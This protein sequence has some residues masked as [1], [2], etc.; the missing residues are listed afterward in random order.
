M[1]EF[2]TFRDNPSLFPPHDVEPSEKVKA[3]WCI[4][5]CQA[6]YS[7]YLL[8]QCSWNYSDLNKIRELRAYGNGAQSTARYMD[9][10]LGKP[11]T[12][13]TGT[14]VASDKGPG[15]TANYA[16]KGYANINFNI[17]KI[18]PK[19]KTIVIGTFMNTEYDVFAD[20]ADDRSSSMRLNEKGKLWVEMKFKEEFARF[21]EE[22]G[23][24]M[25]TPD[26][27][28]ETEQELEMYATMGGFKLKSEI[29]IETA[30]QYTLFL[31]RWKE[32]KWKL[33]TD[34]FEIGKAGVKDYVNPQT[35]K[36]E[37]RYCDPE[38]CI[39]PYKKNTD[40]K[41]MP[42]AGEFCFYTIA[43]LRQLGEFTD[44]ELYTIAN[45]YK[46]F[47]GNNPNLI[48]DQ[49]QYDPMYNYAWN[50]FRIVVLDAEF[51]SDD[52]KYVTTF[53]NPD[54][55]IVERETK[56]GK[57]RKVDDKTTRKVK[58]MMV[59][60]CKW[61]V[62]TE[63]CWDYGHQFDIPRPTPSKA[64]L[65]F[66]F[67]KIEGPPM[68]EMMIQPLDQVQL[69]WIKMQNV[70]A[71]APPP[72]LAVD[73][74]TLNNVTVGDIKTPLELFKLRNQTGNLLY[75]ATTH[76]GYAP[77]ATGYRPIQE[78]QGGA[79]QALNDC[80]LQIERG[81]VMIQ[82]ITGINRVAAAGN[83]NPNDLV[84]TSELSLQASITAL[85]PLFGQYES[86]KERFCQNATLRIQLL[87]KIN[88]TYEVGYFQ[89]LGISNT[90][91]LKIGS[92]INN[93]MFNIRIQARPSAEERREILEAAQVSLQTG[94][95]GQIGITTSDYLVLV[96]FVNQGM[97]KMAQVYLAFRERKAQE[98]AQKIAMQNNQQQIEGN[99]MLEQQKAQAAK[100]LL[101]LQ[102]EMKKLETDLTTQSTIQIDN[103]KH[104]HRMKELTLELSVKSGMNTENNQ[105]KVATTQMANE[106][107]IAAK[108]ADMSMHDDKLEVEE[109]KLNAAKEKSET[110]EES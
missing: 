54:G 58:T 34:L 86:I 60:K 100:E 72:G 2:S 99:K 89:A 49:Y 12:N 37:A 106:T 95:N 59:Y 91:M 62:G 28:P 50:Q 108:G 36:V 97:L 88:G 32:I 69:G 76:K 27:V 77:Q 79:G 47:L 16:R 56:F 101:Q 22:T 110:K 5:F 30:L 3:D 51:K 24:K 15:A 85:Q 45:A 104:E 1:I 82:D 48:R 90:Q 67:S 92:E 96:N 11:T 17:L 64:E 66:H 78:L 94:R 87:V 57:E 25:D 109:M 31:S 43:D 83:P 46:N 102:Q 105:T 35:Q 61:I 42:F 40:Y 44:E 103:N 65:S 19:F 41:D 70:M 38:Y 68:I 13:V 74:G 107:S 21:Q 84:G 81:L 71:M 33:I 55:S 75:S 80:I 63:L 14:G 26:Y 29:A 39:V 9:W 10:M 4:R 53:V 18:A 23:I 73:I 93:A 8:N 52:Y 98:D 20:G 7:M 6:M